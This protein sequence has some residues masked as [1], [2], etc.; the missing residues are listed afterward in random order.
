MNPCDNAIL[1][2]SAGIIT[3]LSPEQAANFLRD[4]ATVFGAEEVFCMAVQAS[5]G[6]Y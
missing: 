1:Q 4:V 2:E 3:H 6:V 5:G